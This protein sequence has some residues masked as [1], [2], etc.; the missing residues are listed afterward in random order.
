MNIFKWFKKNSKNLKEIDFIQVEFVKIINKLLL[1]SNN[2]DE[3]LKFAT[4]YDKIL[5]FYNNIKQE[6]ELRKLSEIELEI[7][8]ISTQII[9][10]YEEF[11][12]SEEFEPKQKHL[13]T[14]KELVIQLFIDDHK[15]YL[16][17]V[18]YDDRNSINLD[19]TYSKNL[20]ITP[21]GR[22]ED[23]YAYLALE[24]EEKETK[25]VPELQKYFIDHYNEL[26]KVVL[27]I[28]QSILN[29]D[30]FNYFSNT[31]FFDLILPIPN[32]TYSKFSLDEK[33]IIISNLRKL[34]EYQNIE[35]SEYIWA[36][37]IL[38]F[39]KV[40][41]FIH[42][43]E[44]QSHREKY[45]FLLSTALYPNN[46]KNSLE[47]EQYFMCRDNV[48]IYLSIFQMLGF[49]LE[50]ITGVKTRDHIFL[51]YK[52]DDNSFNFETNCDINFIF[53]FSSDEFYTNGNVDT[54]KL[55]ISSILIENNVYLNNLNLIQLKSFTFSEIGTSLIHL[56]KYEKAINIIKI[57]IRLFPKNY[58][59]YHNLGSLYYLNENY[60]EAIVFFEK[61]INLD[62]C[63]YEIYDLY[64]ISL[65]KLDKFKE[66]FDQF[67][68]GLEL[69]S[70]YISL[71]ENW[72][73]SIHNYSSDSTFDDL[74]RNQLRELKLKA[75]LNKI[76]IKQFFD[77]YKEVAD[78][79]VFD[80]MNLY[81]DSLD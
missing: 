14:I 53:E 24:I 58:T 35:F 4:I 1:D 41:L 30:K 44:I 80:Q 6:D 78:K 20:K 25:D 69:K 72:F 13:N 42:G 73:V 32:K 15:I 54:R 18:F 11:I 9:K 26:K 47:N 62:P 16:E 39:I 31:D 38:R 45:K 65:T 7:L 37:N 23:T 33:N 10:N 70:D 81:Y 21:N 71:Y 34:N 61:G 2:K 51:R 12:K 49:S 43:T 36:R 68:K 17:K 50:K 5:H 8:E 29:L 74:A 55:K 75:D 64:G 57:A 66:S 67:K 48:K 76:D 56:E 40:M 79:D 3:L 59:N 52:Y 19:Y 22:I 63:W 28:Y 77:K 60:E 46:D 27:P